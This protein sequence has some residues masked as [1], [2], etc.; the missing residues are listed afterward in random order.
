MIILAAAA[1]ALGV[2]QTEMQDIGKITAVDLNTG[3]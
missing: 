3:P 1:P 2:H